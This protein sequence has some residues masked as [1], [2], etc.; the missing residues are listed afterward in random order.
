MN[1]WQYSAN[2]GSRLRWLVAL[3][4]AASAVVATA[5]DAPRA[6]GFS[7]SPRAGT[8]H[9]RKA[10]SAGRRSPRLCVAPGAESLPPNWNSCSN[11]WVS[12]VKDQKKI[13]ACWAFAA[14]ATLETQLLMRGDGAHDFSERNMVNFSASSLPFYL[15]G[16]FMLAA[17]YLLR[18]SGPV[19]ESKDVYVGTTNAWVKSRSPA[20]LSE[21]HVQDIVWVAPLD[22]TE[23]RRREFKSAVMEYG[24]VGTAIG[25]YSSGEYGDTYYYSGSQGA[26][27]AVTAV[28]WDDDFPAERFASPPPG[29]GAWIVKNSWGTAYGDKGF[30]HVSYYDSGFGRDFNGTVVL[31]PGEGE[32]YDAVHGHDCSGPG[33]DTTADGYPSLDCD[34]Q[35]VVFTAAWSERLAAVGV[36]TALCPNEY[37]ISVYTNVTRHVTSRADEVERY[38]DESDEG[39]LPESTSPLEGGAL[40]CRQT[41]TLLRPGFST[42]PL[43]T[44]IP[45]E[46]GSSYAVVYRQTGSEVSTV[47]SY[48]L[49]LS[50][51][52]VYGGV[53]FKPGNG[54]IGWTRD[55][56]AVWH[57]AYDS[58]VY[59]SDMD[60]WA[61]CIKAY[62]RRGSA[63]PAADAPGATEDGTQM[64]VE[65][66]AT[67][68][69]L[70]ADTYSFEALAGLVG[71][72]GR[73]LWASWLAGLDPA[74]AAERDFSVA[75]DMSGG[76]PRIDI[77]PD[78]G[79]AR[80]YTVWGRDSLAP[81]DAWRVVDRDNPS[82]DGARFFRVSIGR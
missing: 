82:S 48:S 54:Y 66:A 73:S 4:L 59:A 41:G 11:G 23:E 37:E 61:L 29:D 38:C 9:V 62:T 51:D 45:L 65:T 30:Y 42:I 44:E 2:A 10:G 8:L 17:G 7:L 50:E 63:A 36:W 53:R 15:G 43:E 58:G 34:L 35:A 26:N 70:F 57:D 1:L 47:V 13:G 80:S 74:N 28:G 12:S 19:D 67:N 33:Y 81:E 69:T 72:N 78:L 39:Y 60:G 5:E 52:P 68:A 3:V 18:W 40:A 25:W 77:R 55:G 31:P 46:A 71:A 75:L 20:L 79:A 76:S 14:L 32:G 24:A 27:H 16:D 22:G 21:M 56:S 6:T 49:P 64:L